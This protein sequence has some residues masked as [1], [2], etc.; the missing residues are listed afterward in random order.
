LF[1]WIV[2]ENGGLLYSPSTHEELALGPEPPPA[3]LALLKA[4][5]VGP[6]SAGR[7]IIATWEPHQA[8]VLECIHEL[9]LDLQVI[10]NKN[11]VMILPAGVNKR[12]GLAAALA[13]LDASPHNCVGIGDAENDHALLSFCECGVAVENALPALKQ[14]ADWVTNGDHGAGV[15]EL[16]THLLASDL[17]LIDPQL[18]RHHILVGKDAHGHDLTLAPY[19]TL[20]LIAG[21]SGAGKTTATTGIIE[22]FAENKYQVCVIDPEGDHSE[23]PEALVSGTPEQP[24]D[25]EQV[26]RM[27]AKPSENVVVNLIGV[28]LADRPRFFISLLG[29]LQE[30]RASTGRP[31]WLVVDEAHHVLDGAF[32]PALLTLPSELQSMLLVTV[33]PERLPELVLRQVQWVLS[34]GEQAGATLSA[35][36]KA[37]HKPTPLV[38][39]TPERPGEALLWRTMSHN[40]DMI[41]LVPG[42]WVHRR[43]KRKY[44][45]G[46]LGPDKSFVFRGPHG[47]LNL[48]AQ[49]LV[50]F[51]E[52]GAGV[53]DAT[54]DHHLKLG[55]YSSWIREHIKDEGLA[56]RVRAVEIDDDVDA[57]AS[58]ARI[59]QM[60]EDAYTN[61]A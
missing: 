58:R 3:L 47:A 11:A 56:E 10:F 15:C 46:D 57:Q 42:R 7:T 12:T 21:G 36:A 54:W 55:H 60:I 26:L 5:G 4:R 28:P 43:H 33:H 44:A 61:P 40:A 30:L 13:R 53:D 49:N 50:A 14:A 51:N 22:R 59:R 34:I 9:G 17:A 45:R 29:R 38:A 6:I 37:A 31:H 41:Q 27:L 2:A 48:R 20:A 18:T 23:L 35:F 25:L 19:G 39:A 52:I 8:T 32:E 1:T 16:I 24:P